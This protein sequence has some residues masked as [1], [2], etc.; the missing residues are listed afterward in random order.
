MTGDPGRH[1]VAAD[2]GV[3]GCRQVE[4]TRALLVYPA[5]NVVSSMPLDYHRSTELARPSQTRAALLLATQAAM[6]RDELNQM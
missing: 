6:P 4:R 5:L 1:V 3:G 2:V